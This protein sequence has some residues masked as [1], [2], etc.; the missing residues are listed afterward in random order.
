M[1][2]F[3]FYKL[4]T[5]KTKPNPNKKTRKNRAKTETKRFE[6][7]FFLKNKPKLIGLNQFQFNYFFNKN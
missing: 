5:K 4:E 6:I 7:G 1:V 2:W 3:W